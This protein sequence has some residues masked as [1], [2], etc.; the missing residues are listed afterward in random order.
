[1][2]RRYSY[3]QTSYAARRFQVLQLG[4]TFAFQSCATPNQTFLLKTYNFAMSR[5]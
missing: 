2:T 4:L 1:M 3:A 5:S